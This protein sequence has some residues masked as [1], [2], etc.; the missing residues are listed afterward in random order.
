MLSF[1]EIKT[2]SEA[3]AVV[4]ECPE[5][6]FSEV[7]MPLLAESGDEYTVA[8]CEAFGCLLIRVCEGGEA[9]FLYPFEISEG[10][11][12]RAAVE[13]IAA[14]ATYQEINLTILDIP[15]EERDVI[16]GLGFSIVQYGVADEDGESFIAEILTEC[17]A[18]DEVPCITGERLMLSQLTDED[19][20]D[21]AAICRDSEL[22]KY[23][24]YDYR[25]DVGECEDF[26]FLREAE[27]ELDMGTAL[28][29]G[30]RDEAGLVGSVVIYGFDFHGSAAAGVRIGREFQGRGYGREASELMFAVAKDMGLRSIRAVIM[31][32]NI[33]SVSLYSKLMRR[34]NESEDRLYFE[35]AL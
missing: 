14:Y 30:V 5:D 28:T 7:V 13:A 27:R 34:V 26:Y 12:I 17:A 25:Q 9:A 18:L 31:K 1:K 21:Y 20:E 11:D 33:S 29:L 24:G 32:E 16:D 22:N 2:E 23:W 35:R 8:L 10:A 3:R 15:Y 19:I 6:I 4:P